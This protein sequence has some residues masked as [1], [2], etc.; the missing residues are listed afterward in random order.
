MRVENLSRVFERIQRTLMGA[1][2][3]VMT[4]DADGTLWAGDVGDDAFECLLEERGVREE[5]RDAL[6][7]EARS[8]GIE[9]RG[10]ATDIAQQLYDS[11][12]SSGLGEA[13]C[14]G[15]MAWAFAGWTPDEIRAFARRMF[16]KR[17]LEERIHE[18]MRAVVEWARER[19]VP[20]WV[21]SASPLFVVQTGIEHF[22]IPSERIIAATPILS[23]GVV[24]ARLADPI[25]YGEGKVRGIER[26]VGACRIVAAFGD[27]AFDLE[28]LGRADVPVAV[29]PKERLRRRAAELPG[30]VELA[31]PTSGKGVATCLP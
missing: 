9:P 15:M 18:E 21:V 1:E 11:F 24:G 7:L 22:E 3:P 5:A 4:T 12:R 23:D 30:L 26:V 28:M 31:G 6:C 10:D 8:V 17:G 2:R 16:L 19:G 20:L 13:R 27:E 14:Y 25:P 29:R